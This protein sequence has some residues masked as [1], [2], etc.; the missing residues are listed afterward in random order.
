MQQAPSSYELGRADYAWALRELGDRQMKRGAVGTAQ[1]VDRWW[2]RIELFVPAAIALVVLAVIAVLVALQFGL[3][4]IVTLVAILLV[5]VLP[6][7]WIIGKWLWNRWE[8]WGVEGDPVKSITGPL[9]KKLERGELPLP[10]G[11]VEIEWDDNVLRVSGGGNVVAVPWSS[12]PAIRREGDRVL[13]MPFVQMAGLPDVGR[14]AIVR[15]EAFPDTGSF[16][17]AIEEWSSYA[18]G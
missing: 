15:S 13:V 4:S 8:F 16:E 6:G 2:E 3:F 9:M 14:M 5:P 7:L 11:S 10:L 12:C 1:R 17:H 18:Q